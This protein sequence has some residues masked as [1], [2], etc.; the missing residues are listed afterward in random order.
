M[1]DL[2]NVIYMDE[3]KPDFSNIIFITGAPGSKW[4]AVSWVLSESPFLYVSKS[5]RTPE[6]LMV[7][8][9]IYGG[10]R[11]TGVYFGPGNELGKSLTRLIHCQKEKYIKRLNQLGQNGI[12]TKHI[13]LD[14]TNLFTIGI[15]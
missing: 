10:V 7:H 6:R 14:A 15:G 8:D 2:D 3:A 12:K 11:H 4:S 1:K 5:D 13:L 9:A